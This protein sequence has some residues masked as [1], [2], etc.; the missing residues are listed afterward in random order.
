MSKTTYWLIRKTCEFLGKDWPFENIKIFNG[1]YNHYRA[2]DTVDDYA[3]C[4]NSKLLYL[5]N[6]R[7]HHKK[8]FEHFLKENVPTGIDHLLF[9]RND[10]NEKFQT[11]EEILEELVKTFKETKGIILVLLS[12]LDITR[13]ETIYHACRRCNKTFLIDFFTANVLKTINKKAKDSVPFPSREDHIDVCVYYPDG[14]LSV[15]EERETEK[16]FVD[17]FFKRQN[18]WYNFYLSELDKMTGGIV[19]LVHPN[20]QADL[21]HYLHQYSGGCLINSMPECYKQDP[22]TRQFLDFIAYKGM[23][24]KDINTSGHVDLPTFKKV[25]ET[26]KPKNLVNVLTVADCEIVEL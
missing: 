19:M 17:S 12:G 8:T 26:V 15:A 20:V 16:K 23:A 24:I 14:L 3:F 10:T 1:Y 13:I 7:N 18:V 9:N 25:V 6:L 2:G 22:K 11:E 21:E 5:C 4:I